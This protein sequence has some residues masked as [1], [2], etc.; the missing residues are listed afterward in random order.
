MPTAPQLVID[1]I[2]EVVDAVR[3]G[4]A[5][6]ATIDADARAALEKALDESFAGSG[7]PGA[8]VGL[9][10]PGKGSWV[11][12]RGVADLKTGRP[13][14]ADLQA[15]IGSIT[16]SFTATIALQ[17]VGEG[18]LSLDDAIDR[19]YPE[20]PEAAAIT[21]RM[22]LNHSSGLP[23]I[24]QLQLDLHCADPTGNRQPG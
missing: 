9:W 10:I 18:K 21:I 19:W 4:E 23:D 5:S 7:L 12:T 15:P 2:R 3:A 16:K 22:L 11:A 14:T 13:M 24:S 20:I 1:A 8:A 6:A 17:L